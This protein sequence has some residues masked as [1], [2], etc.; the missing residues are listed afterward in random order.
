MLATNANDEAAAI[1]LIRNLLSEKKK[2]DARREV[3]QALARHP[4]SLRLQEYRDDL[5][6][7]QSPL[8]ASHEGH[9]LSRLQADATYFSDTAGNRA[10]RAG[11]RFD[12]Q[13]GRNFTNSFRLDE[14]SLWVSQGPKANIFSVQ[15]EGR[16]RVARWLY[17][18]GG[19]GIVRFADNSNRALY[20][21]EL[22]L[23]PIRS[24]WLQ[25][26]F[27]RIPITPTFQ[28]AQFD[29]LAEGWWAR[30]DWQPRSWRVSADFS[31]QH[32]SDSNRTQREDA[33]ILRWVGNSHFAVGLGY[34]Y[35]HSS[36]TQSFA[37]G[38]FSPNQYHSHLG[39]G[40][41][42]FSVGKIYH[43]EYIARYGAETVDQN[44]YQIAWEATAKNRFLLGKFDLGADYTYFH[45]AQST[46]AFRAQVGRVS[47]A[48]RF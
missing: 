23:H 12:L 16:L 36:F 38:Y 28:S 47:A 43:G 13:L 4:S 44:P 33:E 1:G 41:F 30:L 27:S 5:L 14:K 22:I 11:Q 6:K 3:E 7:N 34:E 42:R 8:P 29:L 2:D 39:L 31:K 15:E 19:G 18:G 37:N 21:G 48:Y 45:L 20:R 32:Y 17:V 46:G 26:G 9:A 40:G 35:A 24:F 25:G 10:T